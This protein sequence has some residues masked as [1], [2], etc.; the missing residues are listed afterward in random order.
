MSHEIRTPMNAIIGFSEILFQM[1]EDPKAKEY[2]Q[3]I[4]KASQALLRLINDIL[5]LSKVEAGKLHIIPTAFNLHQLLADLKLIFVHKTKEKG[6]ELD[7]DVDPELPKA[8]VLDEVRLRQILLNLVGN[9]IK[10]TDHG[11]V[12]VR[13]RVRMLDCLSKFRLQVEIADT[14]IGIPHEEKARVFSAFEQRL[15]QDHAKYGGTGLGLT[16]SR[17]LAELMGGALSVADNPEG[18]GTVFTLVLEEVP[19]AAGYK[20]TPEE[21]DASHQLRFE[22]AVVLI[23][24]DIEVNRQLLRTYLEDYPFECLEA[25]DGQMALDLIK[26]HRPNLVLTD[27]KMPVMDGLEVVKAVKADADLCRIPVVAVT[28]SLMGI[29]IEQCR[30]VFDGLLTKPLRKGD[31]I[32]EMAR[33]LPHEVVE[34]PKSVEAESLVQVNEQMAQVKDLSALAKALRGHLNGE[35]QMLLTSLRTSRVKAY[36]ETI[37]RLGRDHE[38]VFIEQSGLRLIAGAASFDVVKIKAELDHF[39]TLARQVE[40]AAAS[41]FACP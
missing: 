38:A 41:V 5:D 17:R 13:L 16:I 1:L 21:A 26:K 6:L 32:K 27:F 28:A 29:Q 8:V 11:Q 33:H 37:A 3:T 15:N 25:A 30:T 7:I 24:D 23:A 18:R 12:T 22:R 39:A 31:L 40:A 2:A 14:G 36:G 19:I 34:A 20:E 4:R 9:A 35:F 10:F